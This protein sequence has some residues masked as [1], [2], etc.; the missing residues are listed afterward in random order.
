MTFRI[1]SYCI[2]ILWLLTIPLFVLAAC[3]GKDRKPANVLSHNDMVKAL[4]QVYIAEQKVSS[5]GLDVDS[6]KKVFDKIKG[7]VFEDAGV[8][9]S[10]FKKSFDYYMDRPKELELI[11]TALVD[12]LNLYEQRLIV[13]PP[14]GENPK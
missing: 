12:T 3:K 2:K 4:A 1:P 10:T 6:A 11:Y 8:S 14:T 13:T 9:D 5:V 7:R